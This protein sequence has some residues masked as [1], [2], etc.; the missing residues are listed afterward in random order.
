MS[1]TKIKI[2]RQIRRYIHN[3]K[4]SVIPIREIEKMKFLL[5]RIC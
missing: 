1:V 2:Y 5:V 3:S 4:V